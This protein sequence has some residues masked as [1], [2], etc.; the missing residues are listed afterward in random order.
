MDKELDGLI[1]TLYAQT[2]KY[3]AVISV[4]DWSSADF[5]YEDDEEPEDE[6]LDSLDKEDRID[7]IKVKGKADYRAYKRVE[8]SFDL[9]YTMVMN[10]VKMRNTIIKETQGFHEEKKII[11]YVDLCEVLITTHLDRSEGYQNTIDLEDI[12]EGMK[13]YQIKLMQKV[14]EGAVK[15]TLERRKARLETEFNTDELNLHENTPIANLYMIDSIL[16]DNPELLDKLNDMGVNID[17]VPDNRLHLQNEDRPHWNRRA[18]FFDQNPETLQYYINERKKMQEG[19]IIGGIYFQP[20]MYFQMNYFKT[21][22]PQKPELVNG[23]MTKVQDKIVTPDIRDNEWLIIQDSYTQAEKEGKILFI[24]ASRRLAK[25]TLIASH[26]HWKLITVGGQLIIAGGSS[27]DLGQIM[28]YLRISLNNVDPV[29]GVSILERNWEKQVVFGLRDKQNNKT[30]FAYLEIINLQGGVGSQSEV[31][32]G[33]TPNAFVI[34][35]A[36]KVS[37]IEQLRGAKPSFDSQYGMRCVPILSGCLTAGNKVRDKDGVEIPIEKVTKETGIY[38]YNRE[39]FEWEIDEIENINPPQNKECFKV[40]TTEQTSHVV[41]CSFDHPFLAYKLGDDGWTMEDIGWVEVMALTEDMYLYKSL[42]E[43]GL[44]KHDGYYYRVT[45]VEPVGR[46]PVYNITTKNTNTYLAN[47]YVTHNTGGNDALSKDAYQLLADPEI[48]GIMEMNWDHLNRYVSPENRTWKERKFGTFA[49][50]QMSQ[51]DKM[52]KVESNLADYL[53]VDEPSLKKVKIMVTDWERCNEI[54]RDFR[55]SIERNR[56]AWRKEVVYYPISPEEIFMSGTENP[57]PVEDAKIHYENLIETKNTGRKVDIVNFEGE[58][59]FV[60]SNK[61]MPVFPHPGGQIDAPV[62]LYDAIPSKPPINLYISSLDDYKQEDSSSTSLGSYYIFKRQAG[63]DPMGDRIVAS[64]TSRPNPH[65]KFH[66]WGHNLIQTFNSMCLMENEDMDFKLYLDEFK[67]ADR[68]LVPT[69]N[70][71]GNLN[72]KMNAKRNYGI[73]PNH[74][75]KAIVNMV[76]KYCNEYVDIPDGQGGVKRVLGVYR[77]PDILLLQEII[78]YSDNLNVDRIVAFGI[79]LIQA[80]Y[81]DARHIPAPIAKKKIKDI[82]SK[83]KD[84]KSIASVYRV[85]KRTA[86]RRRSIFG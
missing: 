69:F 68:W 24:S 57:F 53:Q 74:N 49:P 76:V 56:E 80:H 17:S 26:I 9:E 60:D 2:A 83:P 42:T 47:G 85:G 45:G 34:D 6:L 64:Y 84:T 62:V 11:D 4:R 25:S 36:M 51:R 1:A 54:I 29:F 61:D 86:G 30:E 59:Q 33:Y 38:G 79:V 48:D 67:E 44:P 43:A 31:L 35:E 63:N 15:I 7:N 28:K 14:S 32:A 46:K 27:K 19:I 10:T 75:K 50:A 20:W 39:T 12:E 66:R 16:N 55:K 8:N 3:N 82:D 13:E 23:K 81:L 73:S 22:I 71:E 5:L 65:R 77:I 72:I 41:E 58:I 37:F 78:D 52:V 21:P 40:Y 18:H 70:L